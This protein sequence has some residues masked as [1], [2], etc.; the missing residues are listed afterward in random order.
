MNKSIENTID[1]ERSE[2]M[3]IQ[4]EPALN[5]QQKALKTYKIDNNQT[6]INK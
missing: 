2:T 5:T 1:N 6:T 3:Q 4:T